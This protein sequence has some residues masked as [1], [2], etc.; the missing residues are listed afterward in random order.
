MRTTTASSS[1]ASFYD[2]GAATRASMNGTG[3]R[4]IGLNFSVRQVDARSA[5]D[6]NVSHIP[7]LPPHTSA[8]FQA[9]TNNQPDPTPRKN[10]LPTPYIEL[11]LEILYTTPEMNPRNRE[12]K[13][14][15]GPGPSPLLD[16]GNRSI[17]V[18]CN[19]YV[20]YLYVIR[21]MGWGRGWGGRTFGAPPSAV[22]LA[23]RPTLKC[24][25]ICA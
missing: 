11:E 14:R 19:T 2:V 22:A 21:H 25:A 15:C 18:V 6:N 12:P 24:R 17:Y 8:S 5:P 13:Q 9:K 16:G 10:T 4:D 23:L 7:P 1:S 20:M 3:R